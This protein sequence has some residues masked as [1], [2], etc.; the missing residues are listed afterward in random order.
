MSRLPAL[1]P[2]FW[3]FLLTSTAF[4]VVPGHFIAEKISSH[5]E[6]VE[7]NILLKWSLFMAQDDG[8][9]FA[10]VKEIPL[11]YPLRLKK[12]ADSVHWPLLSIFAAKNKAS[13]IG[14]L[15]QMGLNVP[16]EQ[17]LIPWSD[18]EIKS[19]K[20]IPQPFYR[21]DENVSIKKIDNRYFWEISSADR[22][23]SLIVY[24]NDSFLPYKITGPCPTALR[25]LSVIADSDPCEITFS[26]FNARYTALGIAS[27]I[28]LSQGKNVI[29][30]I[31]TSGVSEDPTPKQISQSRASVLQVAS[32]NPQAW[33]ILQALAH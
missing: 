20:N 19:Q 21:S 1:L 26:Y 31:T 22:K 18:S 32:T 28:E 2:L 11:A 24:K 10:P 33:K 29:L 8:D 17:S 6:S 16:D 7:K 13:L 4:A 5:R 15:R 3:F 9:G 25:G 23:T 14:Q 12:S 27:K 30:S